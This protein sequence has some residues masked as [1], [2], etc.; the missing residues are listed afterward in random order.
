MNILQIASECAPFSKTGGLA[1]VVGALPGALTR[2]G[3]R[4]LTVSPRYLEVDLAKHKAVDS[5]LIWG[6]TAAGVRHDVR[7]FTVEREGAVHVLVDHPMFSGRR[8]IYGDQNGSFGDNHLRFSVLARAGLEAARR[9]RID[10]AGALGDDCVVHCHDWHT[11]L[12]PLYLEAYY[13]PLGLFERSP[14]VLTIHNLAHQGRLPARIF[15]DLELPPRFSGAW[16]LEWYGDVNLLK[17]GLLHADQLTTVSPTFAREMTTTEGG[18][19]LDGLLRHRWGDLTGILNGIDAN[20]WDPT[21]DPHLPAHFSADDLDGKAMCKAELQAELGLPIDGERPLVASVGRLDPQ[22]GTDLLIESVPWLV[23]RGAQVVFLGSAAAAHSAY[24]RQLR[25]LERAYP[26]QVRSWIGFSE[27]LAHR[28]EAAADIFAMPSRFEPC[29]LNQLYSMRYGTV[30]VVRHTGG[31]AD[32]VHTPEEVGGRATGFRFGPFTGF[33]LRE[34][35]HRALHLWETDRDAFDRLRRNGM[36]QDLSW[37]ATV[38]QYEAVY[39]KGAAR[40][41]LA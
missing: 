20:E 7:F 21:S 8:G 3:H 14:T 36:R 1:D 13:R 25:E 11:A 38:A 15:E 23:Q 18:F 30:P 33:A 28:I 9:V 29:G 26:R 34:S 32:S 2:R 22:K 27:G 40:R 19:G 5:G 31:L 10:D 16:A 6:F 24:E 4:V 35:L 12:V 17:A 37:D 41:G 39:R